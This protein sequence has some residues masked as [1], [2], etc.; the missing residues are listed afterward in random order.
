MMTGGAMVTQMVDMMVR[1][2]FVMKAMRDRKPEELAKPTISSGDG[3]KSSATDNAPKWEFDRYG[4]DKILAYPVD[5]EKPTATK[6][7]RVAAVFER[8][9][10]PSGS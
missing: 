4:T 3:T 10:S 1:P 5:A 7:E 2:E 8:S 6:Q 9:A